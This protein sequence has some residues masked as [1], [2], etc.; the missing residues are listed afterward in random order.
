MGGGVNPAKRSQYGSVIRTAPPITADAAALGLLARR[1]SHGAS[2]SAVIADTAKLA[3]CNRKSTQEAKPPTSRPKGKGQPDVAF[4]SWRMPQP[5]AA[6]PH[7]QHWSGL[8]VWKPFPTVWN[9]ISTAIKK[10]V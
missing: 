6:S 2:R 7:G 9:G 1:P 3:A 10:E 4:P 8:W 5:L